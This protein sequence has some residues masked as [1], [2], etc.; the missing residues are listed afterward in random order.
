M[1]VQ[2][3]WRLWL[4]KWL[5]DLES[6]WGVG[7]GRK[8]QRKYRLRHRVQ[9][10]ASDEQ[11]GVWIC[12]VS[13]FFRVLS[14][15]LLFFYL[16]CS[17]RQLSSWLIPVTARANELF[18]LFADLLA[19]CFSIQ[20]MESLNLLSSFYGVYNTDIGFNFQINCLPNLVALFT[21]HRFKEGSYWNPFQMFLFCFIFL[22]CL[23]FFC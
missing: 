14:D 11:T 5:V 19:M 20:D 10:V 7:W 15:F 3:I 17:T 21:L 12:C 6:I 4:S 23:V 16:I 8:W 1:C 13:V 2:S 18:L 22:Y 9:F